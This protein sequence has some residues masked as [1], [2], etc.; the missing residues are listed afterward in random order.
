MNYCSECGAKVVL[1]IPEADNR[2]RHICRSC[3][4]VHY[5]NPKIIA[6]CIPEWG[7]QI[8]L[9]KRGIKPRYG[10][11]T[12]PAGHMETGESTPEAAVRETLEEANAKVEI[13]GLY[14]VIN[15]IDVDQLYMMYRARLLDREYSSGA[16]SLEVGL[17]H[18]QEIPWETLAFPSIRETL[19]Y[20]YRDRQA[21]CYRIRTG[22]ISRDEAGYS[23]RLHT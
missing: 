23:F 14:M 9:C 16:E 13:L 17:Y 2:H 4:T 8:L 6:G 15:L 1:E 3:R 20:Y 21:G 19:R 10:L 22:E 11:W 7:D 18:E 5:C 12:L